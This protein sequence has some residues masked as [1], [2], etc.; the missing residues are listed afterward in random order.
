MTID[1]SGR[2]AG[3]SRSAAQVSFPRLQARTNRFTLGEPKNVTVTAD[4]AT[5]L[6]LRT[7]SGVDRTGELWAFDV[8]TASERLLADPA[9]LLG[10][11][12]EELS[13]AERS[14]RERARESG[15]GIVGYSVDNAGATAVF[16]L[17]GSLWACDVASG[18]CRP[19]PTPGG[20]IDPRVD[21][22]GRY[23]AYAADGCLRVIGVDGAADRVLAG[24]NRDDPAEAEVVWGQAEFIAAEEMDRFRGFWWAPDGE[25]LLVERY[26]NA[27]VQVWYIADPAHPDREPA[28]HRYPAAGTPNADVSLWHVTL[29][30]ERRR[31]PCIDAEFPYLA[32]ASWQEAGALVQLLSRDQ[33]RSRILAP[34]LPPAQA[35]AA[36]PSLYPTC[37]RLAEA[38]DPAWIDL[39][40]GLPALAPDGELL[41]DDAGYA[42]V[43]DATEAGDAGRPAGARPVGAQPAE[44]RP[45][46]A[47]AGI[48]G[49]HR[50]L[51]GGA[52][53][54]PAGMQ[55]RAVLAV[56]ETGVLATVST[57]PTEQQLVLVG[58]DG[59]TTQLSEGAGVHS[60]AMAGDTVVVA[61]ATL[62]AVGTRMT[63][64][65]GIGGPEQGAVGTLTSR[66]ERPPF[67]PDVV[68]L[69]VGAR[70][71]RAALLLP[72][73]HV[74]G[75]RK[76]PV[77]MAPYG[78]PHAQLVLAHARLFLQ[79]QWLADQ[80]FAVIVA[81]GR[82]TPARGPA[83]EREI[84]HEF[85][86][87]TLQDQVD[88]LA[89]VA[90]RYPDDLDTGRVGIMGWSYGGYLSALAVLDRPDVFHAA[91][92]G[93]PVTDWMLYDT[94]YTERYLGLPGGEDGVYDRNSLVG[95]AGRLTRPLML[96]HGLVDDNVVVAHTLRLSAALLAAGRPHEVLPLT[97]ITH[98]A[99]NEVVAENLLLAQVDFFRRTLTAR[100]PVVR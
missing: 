61:R 57:D 77:I 65:S 21:P 93:A 51:K 8:A 27:P 23:V 78:G 89:G 16:T 43:G 22:T 72:R 84:L 24:R 60:G 46:A 98:M 71:L 3:D 12:G 37:R 25:S 15:A 100:N 58:Y 53:L 50:L 38:T 19:L 30:G 10:E 9:Q 76:L 11:G 2:S 17:S 63:V 6:F 48:A 68:I 70:A 47:A 42:W 55:L 5:V 85:A 18:R 88:A 81:D 7:A 69:T 28:A 32:R 99:S 92:A 79:A 29:T 41:V 34:H 95:R 74:P 26:D 87:V 54:T 75:S 97:G 66:A 4:G 1:S 14:R 52:P 40:P 35:Y 49:A 13:A 62:G 45:A 56:T 90:D 33:K 83:W 31:V 86:G 67:T 44:A 20:V 73:D 80:G 96:I 39:V 36:D 59:A 82:G 94:C 64:F 91:V